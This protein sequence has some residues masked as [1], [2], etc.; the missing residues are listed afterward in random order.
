V[1]PLERDRLSKLLGMLG[2][3]HDGEVACAGRMAHALIVAA[4]T[5][6]PELL[7]VSDAPVPTIREWREPRCKNDILD[8]CADF[9]HVL[10]PWERQF[11][12]SIA[13]RKQLSAKQA[14]VIDRILDK[15]RFAAKSSI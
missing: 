13:A 8:R 1:T 10:S 3:H 4:G 5:T 12:V 6:W 9:E 15:I 7:G 2:S 14:A 11:I